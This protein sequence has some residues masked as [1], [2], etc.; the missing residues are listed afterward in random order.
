MDNPSTGNTG[1]RNTLATPLQKQGDFTEFL[2]TTTVVG[3]DALGRPLYQG[4]VFNPST[5]RSVGGIPVRDGYGFDPAT[6]LPIAGQANTIPHN[7]PLW[8]PLATAVIPPMPGL[9]RNTTRANGRGGK[10]AE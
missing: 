1:F 2:D 3:H 7:D 8:S 6:G 4:E 9:D 10:P 5:T